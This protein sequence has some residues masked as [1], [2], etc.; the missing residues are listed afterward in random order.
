MDI[1]PANK[2]LDKE[3]CRTLNILGVV[4][5]VHRSLR[6]LHTMF[7]GFGLF[8]LATEQLISRIN[9]FFQHYHT[10]SNISKKLDMS[11][12]Y[13]QLQT[14]TP[15]NPLTLVYKKQGFLAPLL[16]VKMPWRSLQHFGITL[17]MN[18]PSISHQ[19][20][21]DQILMDIVQEY[22]LTRANVKSLNRCQG[23]LEAI[24]LSDIATADG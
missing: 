19:R 5:T 24:F 11:L 7:G 6:K 14:G 15:H 12:C 22:D 2:L 3:G 17:Q 1:E 10:P 4:R 13:L 16:W 20:K 21:C 23:K 8:N 18:F 9:M